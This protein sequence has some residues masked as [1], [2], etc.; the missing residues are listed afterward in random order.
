MGGAWPSGMRRKRRKKVIDVHPLI[1]YIK[2]TMNARPLTYFSAAALARTPFAPR[3]FVLEPLLAA[4]GLGLVYGSAGIGKSLLALGIAWAA[5]SGAG[6][7]GWQAPRPHRVLYLDGALGGLE[8]QRRLAL[9]GPPPAALSFSLADENRGPR[10]DLARIDGLE[11]L[12]RSWDGPELLVIDD[13]ASLAGVTGD[14]DRWHELGRFLLAQRRKGRA[15]LLLHHTNRDGALRGTSRREDGLDL[16][17]ALRRPRDRLGGGGAR[18]EIHVEKSRRFG[19]IEPILA[20]LSGER[21]QWRE[22]HGG[23]LDRAVA[24]LRQG[25]GAEAM[26]RALGV[27]AATAYRLQRRARQL[28]RLDSRRR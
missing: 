28:G 2:P 4:G 19:R 25:Q 9:F 24:L 21:W 12:V 27:S 10:L 20:E 18:F 3:P 1:N 6:F 5:A 11:R 23:T 17:L 16:V 13:I 14:P 7:L 22:A 8:L 26:G 15:V